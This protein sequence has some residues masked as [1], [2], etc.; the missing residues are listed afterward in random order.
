M[1]VVQ[2]TLDARYHKSGD[3]TCKKLWEGFENS[4]AFKEVFLA[5]GVMHQLQNLG[6]IN[7]YCFIDQRLIHCWWRLF[8]SGFRPYSISSLRD[9]FVVPNHGLTND[10]FDKF[11]F[12]YVKYLDNNFLNNLTTKSHE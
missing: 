6:I 1:P 7:D 2:I 3:D 12:W 8:D 9:V 11:V 4:P 5:A 10:Q